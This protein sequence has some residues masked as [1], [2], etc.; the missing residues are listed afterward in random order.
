MTQNN[1]RHQ[2]PQNAREFKSIEPLLTVGD[3]SLIL[4]GSARAIRYWRSKGSLP[5]PDVDIERTVRWRPETI[6]AWLAKREQPL[7]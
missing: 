3:L 6:E 7:G 2:D 4:K 1:P 5:E